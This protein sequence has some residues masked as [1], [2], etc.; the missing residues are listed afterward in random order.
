MWRGLV[1]PSQNSIT[2]ST[3]NHWNWY[4]YNG[5]E[6]TATKQTQLLNI[7]TTYT[8]AWR[9]IEGDW[10]PNDPAAIIQPDAFPNNGGVGTV[11]G[12]GSNSLSDRHPQSLVAE[13]PVPRRRDLART[14][15]AERVDAC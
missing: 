5:L 13:P 7:I 11:R 1:D 3:N 6:F 8:R 10:Q 4:E 9:H 14:L 2:L 12:S 15:P